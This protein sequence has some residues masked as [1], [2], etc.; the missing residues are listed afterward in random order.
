M[1]LNL[2]SDKI[3][4]TAGDG[5]CGTIPCSAEVQKY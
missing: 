2:V 5:E 1:T 4:F 3:S